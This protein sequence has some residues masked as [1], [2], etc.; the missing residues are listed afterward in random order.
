MY[1][2][3]VRDHFM[4]A[5]SFTGEVFGLDYHEVATPAFA[6]FDGELLYRAGYAPDADEIATRRRTYFEPYH[7][8]ITAEIE[9]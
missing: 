5:H 3:N 9:V 4:I 2:V 7:A 8:A 1:S 6:T